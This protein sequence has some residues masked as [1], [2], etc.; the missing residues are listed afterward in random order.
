MDW[1][2]GYSATYYLAQVDPVTWRDI[3]RIEITGGSINREKTGLIESADIDC[4][5]YDDGERWIRVYLD[6]RQNGAAEHVPLFTGLATSPE[7]EI[8][9]TRVE[10]A[11]QCYSVLKPADDVLL[12]RGWYAPRKSKWSISGSSESSER[13]ARTAES[14]GDA[15]K[16]KMNRNSKSIPGTGRDSSFVRLTSIEANFEII[17]LSAPGRC[18]ID[19][20]T[21]NLLASGY[22]SRPFEMQMN[23]V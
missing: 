18:G 11:L 15:S 21:L 4:T 8:D 9:G 10:N 6:A 7:D 2:K 3:A 23:R 20:M 1:G 5:G 12:L 19:I 17:E 22:I 13:S 16:S 14:V